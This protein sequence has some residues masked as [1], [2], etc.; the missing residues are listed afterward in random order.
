MHFQRPLGAKLYCLV[1]EAHNRSLLLT[2]LR[3]DAQPRL[4]PA[5]CESQVRCPINSITASPKM[6]ILMLYVVCITR[7]LQ[8]VFTYRGKPTNFMY[9]DRAYDIIGSMTVNVRKML[10][11]GPRSTRK[12]DSEI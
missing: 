1:T 8:P 12:L 10:N 3:G 7:R 5:T 11:F 4:E 2:P 6:K 9:I